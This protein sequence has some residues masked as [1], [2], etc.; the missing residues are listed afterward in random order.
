MFISILLANTLVMM[1]KHSPVLLLGYSMGSSLSIVSASNHA[2]DGLILVAPFWQF[3]FSPL[4][5]FI[6]SI[7]KPFLP[8]Y[9]RPFR[10][11]NLSDQQTK[12]SIRNFMP[13]VDLDDPEVQEELRN[14]VLPVSLF[15]QL[16][17]LGKLAYKRASKLE[18]PVL[19]I[20]GGY[21]KLAVP[22]MTKRLLKRFRS[23]DLVRYLEYKAGHDLMNTN[24]SSW[25]EIRAI[26]LYF[27]ENIRKQTG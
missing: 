26:V 9:L 25:Q 5:R 17:R 6:G 4:K 12:D 1:E 7:I 2:S 27:A 13:D 8:R 20:Q 10:V 11:I 23:S 14:T 3:P 15:D 19:I 18:I 22:D 21:D 16:H 24:N